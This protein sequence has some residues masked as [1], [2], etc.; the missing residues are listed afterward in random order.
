MKRIVA[1]AFLLTF[2][3]SNT[4]LR[5]LFKLPVLIHH[6]FEHVEL[7]ENESLAN[8]LKVHYE[9][10][11]N[12]PDDIHGDHENLPFKTT[13]C[14]TAHIPVILQPLQLEITSISEKI[15]VQDTK[16]YSIEEH[17]SFAHLK[18]IWQPPRLG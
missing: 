16:I 3:S 13:D 10:E 15:A 14:H 18:N 6:Y 12:H 17:Y 8:F 9:R 4:E 1:I 5:Q 7:D 2:L 11:I